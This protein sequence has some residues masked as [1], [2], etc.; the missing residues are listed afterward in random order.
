R[1]TVS[2]LLRLLGFLTGVILNKASEVTKIFRTLKFITR[3]A[4]FNIAAAEISNALSN[5]DAL[6][7]LL[8]KSG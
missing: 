6:T 5:T 3:A 8:E 1:C 2:S 4:V 7:A